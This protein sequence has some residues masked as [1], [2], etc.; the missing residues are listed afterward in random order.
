MQPLQ[1]RIF[2][3]LVLLTIGLASYGQMAFVDSKFILN[4]MPDY[5]DSLSKINQATLIWQKEI[6]D[7]QAVVDK[8]HLDFE[9]D[10]VMLSDEIKKKRADEIFYHEKEL[11][12][13]QRSRFG[14]EGDLFKIR[15]DLL[16]PLEDSVNNAIQ[17]TA[18]RLAYKVVLDKSEGITVLYADPKL[19]ITREVIK[20][21][22]MQ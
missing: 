1:K 7:K 10:E 20:D 22:G 3:I 14:Y 13:L 2:T 19:D 6:D 15:R 21:M 16:K 8:M 9:R 17:K 18:T 11:R 5:R 4:R 12:D